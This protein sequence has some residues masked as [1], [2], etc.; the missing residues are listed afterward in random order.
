MKKMAKGGEFKKQSISKDRFYYIS[1]DKA[2]YDQLRNIDDDLDKAIFYAVLN[3]KL[4]N[5]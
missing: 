5:Q 4:K 1:I 3:N 2:L